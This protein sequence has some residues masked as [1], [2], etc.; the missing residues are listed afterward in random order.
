MWLMQSI[1]VKPGWTMKHPCVHM[2]RSAIS[3]SGRG[4]PGPTTKNKLAIKACLASCAVTSWCICDIARQRQTCNWQAQLL[5]VL[6]GYNALPLCWIIAPENLFVSRA[7]PWWATV[8]G[9]AANWNH[10]NIVGTIKQPLRWNKSKN[11]IISITAVHK[12]T[13]IF[14]YSKEANHQWIV[15]KI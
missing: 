13:S 4:G 7:E 6:A 3:Q 8:F 14:F 5:S 10:Q 12:P 15:A 11:D 1:K 9:S 2:P